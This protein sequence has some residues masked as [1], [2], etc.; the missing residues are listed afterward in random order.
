MGEEGEG[1]FFVDAFGGGVEAEGDACEFLFEGVVEV[2]C[3]AVAF[4]DDDFGFD[5][6]LDDF[7]LAFDLSFEECCPGGG[8][9]GEGEDDAEDEVEVFLGEFWGVAEKGD[10][11]V[12]A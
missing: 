1:F 4:F 12:L 5:F 8:E 6:L 3:D 10:F 2:A 11:V 7:G 9:D